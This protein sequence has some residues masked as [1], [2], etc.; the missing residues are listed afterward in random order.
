MTYQEWVLIE[1][2][3]QNSGIEKSVW[4]RTQL[5]ENMLSTLS[6]NPTPTSIVKR[7]YEMRGYDYI[8][9][10]PMPHRFSFRQTV[11]GNPVVS[12]ELFSQLKS[13][14]RDNIGENPSVEILARSG[15][16]DLLVYDQ[17]DDGLDDYDGEKAP[18]KDFLFIEVKSEND[19]LRHSQIDWITRFRFLPIRIAYVIPKE[20]WAGIDQWYS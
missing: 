11:R 9:T 14:I 19:S 6:D 12:D 7:V 17:D 1:Y 2:D 4:K 18:L 10:E 5:Q 20:N 15:L 8:T 16:P 13:R 3:L